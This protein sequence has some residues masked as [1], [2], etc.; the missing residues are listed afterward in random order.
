MSSSV[1]SSGTRIRELR[2]ERGLS[3]KALGEAIG[4]SQQ[5]IANLESTSPEKSKYYAPISE[6]FNVPLKLLLRGISPPLASETCFKDPDEI[7]TI[8]EQAL[9]AAIASFQ[10]IAKERENEASSIDFGLIR[11][12]FAIAIRGIITGDYVTASFEVRDLTNKD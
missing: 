3:Q 9:D 4:T 8:G 12:A 11:D 1:S 2:I 10:K 5:T 7:I 6:L